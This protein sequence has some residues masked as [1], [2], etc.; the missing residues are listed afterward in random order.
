[1]WSYI[2]GAIT[3]PLY[4]IIPLLT[5]WVGVFPIAISWWAALALTM[6]YIAQSLVLNYCKKVRGN[7]EDP[8]PA[9]ALRHPGPCGYW[10]QG[11]SAVRHHMTSSGPL[12]FYGAP[13]LVRQALNP[14][15]DTP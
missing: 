8:E 7:P 15:L 3:T 14:Q 4:I 12:K 10:L 6:Y 13:K 1:M 9:A 11:C 5:I 2:V